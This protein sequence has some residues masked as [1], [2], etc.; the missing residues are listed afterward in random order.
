MSG[1]AMKL[2]SLIVLL[3][4]VAAP[5]CGGGSGA[6]PGGSPTPLAASFVPELSSPTANDVAMAEGAKTNDVVTINVTMTDASGVYATAFDVV[7]DDAHTVF[8]GFT[9]GSV[10]EQGGNSP[11]YTVSPVN[12]ATSP[13]RVVVG[14]SRIGNTAT[15]V[16][17]TK[18]VVGLQFR[19]KQAGVF[20]LSI[21]NAIVYDSHQPDPQSIPGIAWFAGAV[22]GV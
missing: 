22:T 14:V 13:G 5:A 9:P 6:S 19:V 4:L 17:G 7:Y 15:N 16:S 20:P 2:G 10:F 18:T 8:V 12:G 3:A 21:Q 1:G 11:N